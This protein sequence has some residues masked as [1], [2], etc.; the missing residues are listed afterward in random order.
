MT[1]AKPNVNR[2]FHIASEFGVCTEWVDDVDDSQELPAGL[3]RGAC[4]Q[5]MS[6]KNGDKAFRYA[7]CPGSSAQDHPEMF[8]Y[9]S[10][11]ANSDGSTL[12]MTDIPV[13]EFCK[14]PRF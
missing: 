10:R 5:E 8:V 7:S 2:P 9:Y 6:F 12:D 13:A 14:P 11:T 4:P 3:K 1:L